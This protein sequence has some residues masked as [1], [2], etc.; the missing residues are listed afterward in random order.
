MLSMYKLS[1]AVLQLTRRL[2]LLD[3][4]VT[5]ARFNLAV[6]GRKGSLACRTHD[7]VYDEREMDLVQISAL[8]VPSGCNCPVTAAVL[9]T[10]CAIPELSL[11]LLALDQLEA[12]SRQVASCPDRAPTGIDELLQLTTQLLGQR[13]L[14]D[15]TVS[16][17]KNLSTGTF[18][19][20][21]DL[22]VDVLRNDM[23]CRHRD[24]LGD[25][26]VRKALR[27]ACGGRDD[28]Q[29]W[30]LLRPIPFRFGD[31]P[32]M[33]L[34]ALGWAITGSWVPDCRYAST[35]SMLPY[36]AYDH[37]RRHLPGMVG[38]LAYPELSEEVRTTALTLW[39]DA[40]HEGHDEFDVCVRTAVLL[41]R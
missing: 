15:L 22:E 27:R 35:L 5:R 3:V 36:W 10:W 40:M 29:V 41:C 33:R 38:S 16:P 12:V 23:D 20:L 25:V 28:E 34:R 24:L 6:H 9:A 26:A 19:P 1:D 31:F 32:D 7:E 11:A 13:S 4:E 8:E 17:L 37:L 30:V 21:L 18:Q 2:D 39:Q 14:F